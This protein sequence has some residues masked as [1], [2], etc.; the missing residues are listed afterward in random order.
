MI[1]SATCTADAD[2]TRLSSP[3][4]GGDGKAYAPCNLTIDTRNGSAIVGNFVTSDNATS[5]FVSAYGTFPTFTN[6][7]VSTSGNPTSIITPAP[8]TFSNQNATGFVG[9]KF[10]L[11]SGV[12]VTGTTSPTP[13]QFAQNVADFVGV[14]EL[15]FLIPPAMLLSNR[16]ASIGTSR[17]TRSSL[18]RSDS[19][20]SRWG[21]VAL[22]RR[23]TCGR[24]IRERPPTK[25]VPP[26]MSPVTGGSASSSRGQARLKIRATTRC[27]GPAMVSG[28]W[29]IQNHGP[30]ARTIS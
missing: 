28:R 4:I 11:R 29:K 24:P 30:S 21:R 22:A 12:T 7:N 26:A 17:R 3:Y 10:P 16:T 9:D 18:R 14:A 8:D 25:S 2:A 23:S 5:A 1:L 27:S 6:V 15:P 19:R 20:A 13:D